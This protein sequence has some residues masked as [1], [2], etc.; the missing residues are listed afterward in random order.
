S[1]IARI[2]SVNASVITVVGTTLS[3][4][5]ASATIN[6]RNLR[7]GTTERSHLLEVAFTDL[8]AVKYFTGM[9]IAN[10]TVNVQSQQIVTQV[11]SFTGKTGATA[12]A[13]L[14]TTI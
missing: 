1:A 5:T 12:S 11:F 10:A 14:A 7:N 2:A 6:G 3:A 13:T 4:T 8:N 9:E